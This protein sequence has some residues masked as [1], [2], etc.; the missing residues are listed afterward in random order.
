MPAI[1]C[2]LSSLILVTVLCGMYYYP[3]LTDEE[4]EVPEINAGP[5]LH[6]KEVIK[7]GSSPRL[8]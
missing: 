6:N 2:A 7:P 1:I 5:E 4:T 8:V 3:Q